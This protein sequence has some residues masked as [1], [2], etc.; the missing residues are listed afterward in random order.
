MDGLGRPPG[1]EILF[2]VGAE[3]AA[4]LGQVFQQ[5][6]V[7]FSRSSAEGAGANLGFNLAGVSLMAVT[8]VDPAEMAARTVAI[9]GVLAKFIQSR[10]RHV[11]VKYQDGDFEI[12]TPADSPEDFAR[13]L[14][15]VTTDRPA[16]LWII[17]RR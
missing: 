15:R 14:K 17:P 7:P 5:S 3:D 6:G 12:M 2:G 4:A 1:R 11:Y 16:T 9:A 10:N 13:L 8:L